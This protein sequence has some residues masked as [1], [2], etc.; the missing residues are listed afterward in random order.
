MPEAVPKQRI[1]T[2]WPGVH[3]DGRPAGWTQS[4]RWWVLDVTDGLDAATIVFAGDRWQCLA[5]ELKLRGQAW[6]SPRDQKPN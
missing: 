2:C 3:D 6:S 1:F 5:E 4:T